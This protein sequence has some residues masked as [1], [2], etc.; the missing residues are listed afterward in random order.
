MVLVW[1]MDLPTY[2]QTRFQSQ[3]AAAQALGVSQGT[4]SHW[5]TG[6]RLPKPAKAREIVKHSRGRLSLE[7]IYGARR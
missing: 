1:A 2:L 7:V 4:I 3:E 6:R 5:V